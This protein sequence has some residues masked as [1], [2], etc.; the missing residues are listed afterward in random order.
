MVQVTAKLRYLSITPRKVNLVAR[1][2]Q[3]R[4]VK[5]AKDQLY[6]LTK[7]AAIPLRKLLS[8]AVAN[9]RSVGLVS[10]EFIVKEVRVT[11]G[12]MS[13]RGFPRS[14]GRMDMKR[15]RTSHITLIL[16]EKSK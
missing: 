8:S 11:Q 10:K 4:E 1:L 3:G 14:R 6:A 12:P 2:I 15:K 5:E 7:R 9:A 13:K 16:E